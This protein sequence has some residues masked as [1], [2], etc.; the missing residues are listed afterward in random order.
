MLA[1]VNGDDD[2]EAYATIERR[3]LAELV[4]AA[5]IATTGHIAWTRCYCEHETDTPTRTGDARV[6][7]LLF[8]AQKEVHDKT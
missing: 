6:I 1:L 3:Q 4:R 8:S 7:F 2:A 5:A